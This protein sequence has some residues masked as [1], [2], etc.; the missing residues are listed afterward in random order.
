M[1]F[2]Q[3][4]RAMLFHDGNYATDM[5]RTKAPA[6]RN[7]NRVQPQLDGRRPLSTWTWGGSFGS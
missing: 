1:P 2:L 7:G 5:V 6:P 3:K 4:H